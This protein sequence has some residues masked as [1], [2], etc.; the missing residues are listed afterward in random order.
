LA[1]YE[2]GKFLV[3]TGHADLAETEFETAVRVEPN[4][5]EARFVQASFY[6]VGKRFAKAEDA[7][8]ALAELDKDKPEGRS[9]LGDFYS[10]IGRLDE[11]VAIYREVVTKS[12]DYNQ[13]HYRLAEI[14][15]MHGDVAAARTEVEGI[16]KKDINDRQAMILRA[17]I[18]MQ[19][20]EQNDLK[21]AMADL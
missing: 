20:G 7:Y 11:A 6:L 17:R 8:K 18:Q 19:S 14:L 13:G 16:L 2:Y 21:V 1:H 12:P 3:Q 9:V 15:L 5:R 10:S 4:N